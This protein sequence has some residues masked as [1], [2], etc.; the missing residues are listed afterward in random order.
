ML[1]SP[2]LP[3]PRGG[4]GEGGVGSL[5]LEQR[6]DT[7][8]WIVPPQAHNSLGLHATSSSVQGFGDNILSSLNR[9]HDL[10]IGGMGNIGAVRDRNYGHNTAGSSLTLAGAYPEPPSVG[11]TSNRLR[12]TR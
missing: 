6:L 11:Q 12:P 9:A 8:I 3:R 7:R 1:Q 2:L 4:G 10:L 5:A